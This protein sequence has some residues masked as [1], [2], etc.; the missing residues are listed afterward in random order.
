MSSAQRAVSGPRS[1]GFRSLDTG[2]PVVGP[3]GVHT[4]PCAASCFCSVEECGAG[5]VMSPYTRAC[6]WSLG[7]A[8]VCVAPFQERSIV[9]DLQVD[10]IKS[11]VLRL[12]QKASLWV[13][14]SCPGDSACARATWAS[15]SEC[16]SVD[17]ASCFLNARLGTATLLS[18]TVHTEGGFSPVSPPSLP[19]T[20]SPAPAPSRREAGSTLGTAE[21]LLKIS[22]FALEDEQ[23]PTP[24]P[25][26]AS[27]T[28]VYGINVCG[29]RRGRDPGRSLP[30]VLR[31]GRRPARPHALFR[32]Q[33]LASRGME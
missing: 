12:S 9:L 11:S 16:L 32:E 4:R 19:S 24:P 26:A 28:S 10:G 29:I 23:E 2:D 33:F 14:G 21:A 15:A 13:P 1:S 3:G 17:G 27:G 5:S 8:N 22:S 30:K 31:T 18:G 20:L 6:A 7:T 25:S